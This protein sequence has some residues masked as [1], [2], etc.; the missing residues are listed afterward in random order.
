VRNKLD[1]VARFAGANLVYGVYDM[2]GQSPSG[3]LHA[4]MS[5]RLRP[6]YM[7][8]VPPER[9]ADPDLS[10]LYADLRGLP[11]ALFTV[12][13]LDMLLEESM[14][15]A[16]RWAAA[17]NEVQLDVYPDSP[18][19]FDIFPSRMAAAARETITHWMASVSG[20]GGRRARSSTFVPA[21]EGRGRAMSD[22]ER[23]A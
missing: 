11:P 5:D 18:H 8:H 6:I 23:Q 1:A 3:R 21:E 16:A 9:R 12:G 14:A 17:G 10:P 15:M 4:P 19:G 22:G 13:T 20:D 7:G 2:S